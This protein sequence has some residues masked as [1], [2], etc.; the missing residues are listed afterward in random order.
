MDKARKLLHDIKEIQRVLKGILRVLQPEP[1]KGDC[2]DCEGSGEVVCGC[3]YDADGDLVLCGE[4][5]GGG[6]K[7]CPTCKGTGKDPN[8]DKLS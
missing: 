2:P 4:C 1:D 3:F 5:N 8:R 7:P 6:Y